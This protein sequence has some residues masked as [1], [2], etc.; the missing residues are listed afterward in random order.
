MG[1]ARKSRHRHGIGRFFG[2][3]TLAPLSIVSS[4]GDIDPC[5]PERKRRKKV[6]P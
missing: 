5:M 2:D 3:R 6:T 4:V 1:F